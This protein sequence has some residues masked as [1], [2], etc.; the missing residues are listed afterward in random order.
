MPH[1]CSACWNLSALNSFNTDQNISMPILM[2]ILKR[3]DRLLS[4]AGCRT[5]QL[6]CSKV[7]YWRTAN[8]P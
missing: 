2:Q 4:Q 8:S 7:P 1:D 5:L 6:E 3:L